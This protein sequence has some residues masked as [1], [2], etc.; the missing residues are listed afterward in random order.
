MDRRINYLIGL[1]TETCNGI[2]MDDNK[3][4]LTQSLVYDL[5]WAITDKKG[6]IYKTRSFVIA[7]TFLGMKDVMKSAYYAE[8]IPK[9][10]EDIKNGKRILTTFWK[11]RNT[12]LE[13]IKEYN[14][15]NIFAHN[16]GFDVRALNNTI[17]YI[18][19]SKFRWFFPRKIEIWDTLK[20]A[21]QTIGKQKMY[22][23]FCLRN[24][25]MTK[26]R[27][28]QVRLTAEILYRY[29]SGQN[30]FI[31][32]HTALDDAEI[33]TF[34]LS[35]IATRHAVSLGIK[36]FPFRDLGTTVEFCKRKTVT[37]EEK[38][39]VRVAISNY[40]EN[41]AEKEGTAYYTQMLNYLA[42]IESMIGNAR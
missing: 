16:A 10:W 39:V 40:L 5:G 20:M 3:I 34:I 35:K 19:K 31:E 8:K 29:I 4:D 18:T 22:K 42:A 30:D 17:R 11:V 36:F 33:E 37:I 28:P 12:L 25:Y 9:Y 6:R 14:V 7:E 21:R 41:N 15:K 24:N 1:D 27:K 2:M 13:D 23:E 38:T 26:H 32:S